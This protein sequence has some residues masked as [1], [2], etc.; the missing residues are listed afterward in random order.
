MLYNKLVD[1]FT[2]GLYNLLTSHIEGQKKQLIADFDN[3]AKK[4]YKLT[5]T[6]RRLNRDLYESSLYYCKDPKKR[7]EL[8]E[9]WKDKI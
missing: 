4:S 5:E 7:L 6:Q 1:R 9:Y 8:Y 2:N 3:I